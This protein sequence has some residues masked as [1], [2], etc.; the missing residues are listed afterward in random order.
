MPS[1][2]AAEG[3]QDSSFGKTSV[4]VYHC[5]DCESN[6]CKSS[7]YED[8]VK[9][10]ETQNETF[11]NEIIQLVTSETHIIMCFQQENNFPEGI[12]AIVWEKAMGVGDSCGN[13]NYGGTLYW[14][15]GY[16]HMETIFLVMKLNCYI[17]GQTVRLMSKL[18]CQNE[19]L[20]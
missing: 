1:D 7:N 6:V 11:S 16:Q 18:T 9:I 13:L 19:F 2:A 10:G 15:P 8:F 14:E 20:L 3:T 4:T 12:Y 5:K 17:F